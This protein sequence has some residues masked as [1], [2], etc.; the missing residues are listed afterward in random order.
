MKVPK[1]CR[2]HPCSVPVLVAWVVLFG[3]SPRAEGGLDRNDASVPRPAVDVVYS[4]T[5]N[6]TRY[7]V[8]AGNCTLTWITR[9]SEIGVVKHWSRC[10]A[11]LA[12]QIQLLEQLYGEFLHRDADAQ[13]LRTLFWG[14]LD[15]DTRDG[16]RELSLR[17]A[18]AAHRS[19][20][21]DARPGRPR[22]G[23]L[24]VFVKELANS[25]LIYP[26]L[27]EVFRRF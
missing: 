18:L 25:E 13:A 14:R 10:A 19:P 12:G 27:K 26:E 8:S 6:A 23:D 20:D 7:S 2:R 5:E 24:N 22:N 9:K 4:A 15:P 16:P 21:W 1:T 11:P 3:W 17:L